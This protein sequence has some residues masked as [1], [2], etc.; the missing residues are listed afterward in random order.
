MSITLK[1]KKEFDGLLR[2]YSP[3][4]NSKN[5][6]EEIKLAILLGVS[7][8]GRNTI[9]NHLVN[10]GEYHFIISNTTRPPKMRDGR[11]EV[12]GQNYYFVTEE[13]MLADIEGGVMLEAELI[14]DQQVSGISIAEIE[15]AAKSGLIPINEVDIGGT[16]AIKAAKPNTDFFFIVPP[17]YKEWMYRLHGREVISETELLNRVRTA[18]YILTEALKDD[19]FTFLVNDSSHATSEAIN[20]VMKSGKKPDDSQA[21]QVAQ[22]IL[23]A[24]ESGTH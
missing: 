13:K 24:I 5:A 15:H 17:T 12:H 14:H 22:A 8:A 4:Q 2:S 6:L 1:H 20:S 19:T 10:S 7:G 9:I 18:R 21:R 23:D 16:R 11:M 3:S